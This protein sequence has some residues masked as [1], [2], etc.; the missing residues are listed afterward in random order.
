MSIQL[1][2]KPGQKGT[3]RL[4]LVYGDKL[5]C[6]RYRYDEVRRRRSKTV[7]LVVEECEWMPADT[8]V[9]VRVAWGERD[10]GVRVKRAGGRWLSEVKLW[11]LPY[12]KAVSLGLTERIV[13]DWG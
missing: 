11:E 2:R 3:K 4:L 5:V 10:L 8:P 1:T 6:V 9:R 13:R 7:E 12:G